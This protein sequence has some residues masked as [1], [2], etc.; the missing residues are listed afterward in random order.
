MINFHPAKDSAQYG[1]WIHVRL[2]FFCIELVTE[3]YAD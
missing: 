3:Q 1:A 2:S